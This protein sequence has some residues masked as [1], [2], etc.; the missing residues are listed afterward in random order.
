METTQKPQRNDICKEKV[1]ERF[2]KDSKQ[3]KNLKNKFETLDRI[4]MAIDFIKNEEREYKSRQM[5]NEIY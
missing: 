3:L 1:S 5:E 2:F 4:D